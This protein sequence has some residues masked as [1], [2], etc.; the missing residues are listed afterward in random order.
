MQKKKLV[1]LVERVERAPGLCRLF[2]EAEECGAVEVVHDFTGAMDR[3]KRAKYDLIVSADALPY[4]YQG[5][6]LL[7]LMRE[8]VLGAMNQ[9]TMFVLNTYNDEE[10]TRDTVQKQ[11]RGIYHLRTDPFDVDDLLRAVA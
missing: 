11:L 6:N 5:R 4:E 1:L 3:V 9:D 8:G 10:R 2:A 7:A